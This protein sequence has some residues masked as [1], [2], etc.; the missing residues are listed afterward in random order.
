MK[1]RHLWMIL[2]SVILLVFAVQTGWGQD[3]KMDKRDKEFVQKAASGGMM[4]VAAGELASKNA[5]S[6]DVRNFGARMVQDHGQANQSL[7]EIAQKKGVQVPG[8]MSKKQNKEVDK[9]AEKTGANFDR[10]YM[11]LML[12]EHRD[13]I[14]LFEKQARDGRDPDLKAF[15]ESTLPTLREHLAMGTKIQQML[16]KQK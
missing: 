1:T 6:E 14:K 2:S 5:T 10:D 8:E 3:M 7:M 9:L 13:A 11:K 16:G 12:K 15:A 4:E